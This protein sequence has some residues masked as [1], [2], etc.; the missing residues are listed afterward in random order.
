MNEYL[1]STLNMFIQKR[2]QIDILDFQSRKEERREVILKFPSCARNLTWIML[3]PPATTF[4][5]RGDYSHFL[6][7]ETED[8]TASKH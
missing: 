2:K 4:L 5:T 6:R 3:F 7:M 1:N 8:H